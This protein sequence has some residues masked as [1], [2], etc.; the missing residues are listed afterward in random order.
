MTTT[1]YRKWLYTEDE[2]GRFND[3]VERIM[4]AHSGTV[5]VRNEAV[6][7][8]PLAKPLSECVVTLFTTGG[9]H[10]RNDT[11]FDIDSP[12]GDWTSRVIP[13]GVDTKDLAVTHSHYSHV[14][15]DRDV[16]CMFPLDRLRELREEGI[17]GGIAPVAY[18]IMGF[19]PDPHNLVTQTA[20]A[21]AE[22]L[23]SSGADLVFM[24]C[25]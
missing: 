8:T 7:W 10:L 4:T 15:A 24:T 9:V 22:A 3:W 5:D 21:L 17:I 1:E 25:G 23:R 20:P 19:N 11:P 14:D 2:Q 6:N 18:S 12:D 16:N 13:T